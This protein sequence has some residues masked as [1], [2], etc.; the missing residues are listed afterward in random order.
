LQEDI[1]A[2]LE[3]WSVYG[4]FTGDMEKL[5][6]LP[7]LEVRKQV[8]RVEDFITKWSKQVESMGTSAMKHAICRDV[9]E[10]RKCALTYP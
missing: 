5:L 2:T 7:W 8:H 6:G 4:N 1:N 9:G 3:A 10:V